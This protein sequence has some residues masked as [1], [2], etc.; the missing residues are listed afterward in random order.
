MDAAE[1]AERKPAAMKPAMAKPDAGG[2]K[3]ADASMAHAKPTDAGTSKSASDKQPD[4]EDAGV[5]A[6]DPQAAACAAQTC[7]VE[8]AARHDDPSLISTEVPAT[9]GNVWG[10]GWHVHPFPSLPTPLGPAVNLS[11]NALSWSDDTTTPGVFIGASIH[12]AKMFDPAAVLQRYAYT[13]CTSTPPKDWTSPG[14]TGKQVTWHCAQ[15]HSWL[16]VAI[17]PS[18]HS[19]IA[20]MEA[21]L[22]STC[23]LS[24]AKHAIDTLTIK[25]TSEWPAE[26]R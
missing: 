19:Y 5:C 10:N 14:Y 15:G 21:K 17:W 4:D 24:Y 3:S 16:D 13:D 1:P 22:P 26:L 7:E 18:D 6:R 20:M 11:A 12:L 9:W 25:P 8:F 2:D 23:D